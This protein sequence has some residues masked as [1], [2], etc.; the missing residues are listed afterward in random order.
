MHPTSM[1]QVLAWALALFFLAGA[2]GNFTQ[3]PASIKADYARWGYP[4][5]FHWLTGALELVAA[6]LLLLPAWRLAGA[7]LGGG[8]M[9][10]AAVTVLWRPEPGRLPPPAVAL[11][12]CAGLALGQTVLG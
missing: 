7:A 9:L 2:I 6:V 3:R 12:L 10:A 1:L 8:V 4:G 11:V 5:W